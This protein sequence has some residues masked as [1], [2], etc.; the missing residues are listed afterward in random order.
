MVGLNVARARVAILR[1]EVELANLAGNLVH[2]G[3]ESLN[4]LSRPFSAEVNP[5]LRPPF[6]ILHQRVGPIVERVRR[7]RSQRVAPQAPNAAPRVHAMDGLEEVRSALEAPGFTAPLLDT[8][9][10]A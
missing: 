10:N 4:Q 8:S 1:L 9:A 7:S 3:L 5:K 2:A 6:R